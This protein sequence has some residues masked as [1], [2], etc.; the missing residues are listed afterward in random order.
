MM[1]SRAG[2]RKNKRQVLKRSANKAA[3]QQLGKIQ[4]ERDLAEIGSQP[5][6]SLVLKQGLFG[7]TGFLLCGFWPGG[8]G[9]IGRAY[10]APGIIALLWRRYPIECRIVGLLVDLWT[11]FGRRAVLATLLAEPLSTRGRREQ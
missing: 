6:F 2:K 3:I 8:L 9:W 7:K 10:L 1:I 5:R 11:I 4:F